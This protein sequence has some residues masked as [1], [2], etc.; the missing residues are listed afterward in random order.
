[1]VECPKSY[2]IMMSQPWSS[3]AHDQTDAYQD[4]FDHQWKAKDQMVS[5]H[6]LDSDCSILTFIGLAYQKGR[7]VTF[8]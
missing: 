2:G 8:E 1:M 4:P 7:R 5:G 6:D 3:Y